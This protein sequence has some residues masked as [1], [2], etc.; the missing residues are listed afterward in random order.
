MVD[1]GDLLR[2]EKGGL[3]LSEQGLALLRG[4]REAGLVSLAGSRRADRSRR[5]RS[6]GRDAAATLLPEDRELYE[7][8]RAMRRRVA[9]EKGV[10]P[11][12]IFSDATLR[13]I[14]MTRPTERGQLLG[15][16]GVGQSKLRAFGDL[17]LREVTGG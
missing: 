9:D 8:L 2:G 7:R 16:R 4:E 3:R 11:Y 10:P 6:G 15:V 14:A 17:V 1:S 12:V 13:E 5:D